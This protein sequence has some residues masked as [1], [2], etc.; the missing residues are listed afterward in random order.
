[1][2]LT[3]LTLPPEIRLKI[4]QLLIIRHIEY[5]FLKWYRMD[6]PNIWL[7]TIC[8]QVHRGI[9]PLL[10]DKINLSFWGTHVTMLAHFIVQVSHINGWSEDDLLDRLGSIELRVPRLFFSGIIGGVYPNDVPYLSLPS[11]NIAQRLRRWQQDPRTAVRRAGG[12]SVPILPVGD[13]KTVLMEIPRGKEGGGT[14]WLEVTVCPL[15]KE[16]SPEDVVLE[17]QRGRWIWRTR[18]RQRVWS[19]SIQAHVTRG[20]YRTMRLQAES[21]RNAQQ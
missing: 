17:L 19:S 1:M 11:A 2:A 3:L 20:F 13:V 6:N 15:P 14:R 9:L 7:L 10:S 18:R 16:G 4:W 8:Q 5:Y 12:P 21:P